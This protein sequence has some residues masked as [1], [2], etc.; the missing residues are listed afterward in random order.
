VTDAVFA[1]QNVTCSAAESISA[2]LFF[3]PPEVFFETH[4]YMAYQALS[5]IHL[6]FE[7]GLLPFYP[8][9]Q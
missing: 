2:A 7:A 8:N 9:M 4:F 6:S 5:K 3:I 1:A